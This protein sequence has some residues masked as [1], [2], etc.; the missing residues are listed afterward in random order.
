[1]TSTHIPAPS[2]RWVFWAFLGLAV[3]YLIVEHR[4]HIAGALSWL[5]LGFLLLCPLM[6]VLGHGGPGGH[7]RHGD[8]RNSGDSDLVRGPD[9]RPTDIVPTPDDAS[10]TFPGGR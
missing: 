2:R 10:K 1:M 3:F 4:A 7:G 6:H 8:H 9:P 5:P